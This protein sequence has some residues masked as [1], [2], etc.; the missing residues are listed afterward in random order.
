MA[1]VPVCAHC[2][3]PIERAVRVIG[4]GGNKSALAL[5]TNYRWTTYGIVHRNC[6][7]DMAR[8]RRICGEMPYTLRGEEDTDEEEEITAVI[9]G[10]VVYLSKQHKSL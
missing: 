7:V 10:H 8:D 5:N 3:R 9:D 4:P 6:P 2:K 1:A